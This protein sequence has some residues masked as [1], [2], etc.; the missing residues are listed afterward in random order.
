MTNTI[1]Y[2]KRE[3]KQET[4]SLTHSLSGVSWFLERSEGRGGAVGQAGGGLGGLPTCL[5][6]PVC[7]DHVW[8]SAFALGA[9]EAAV[10]FW[11]F[12]ILL[13]IIALSVY[14]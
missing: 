11:P 8:Y 3:Q 5:G 1:C 13:F 7:R 12:C 4:D 6:G 10:G 14:D 9:S 2:S